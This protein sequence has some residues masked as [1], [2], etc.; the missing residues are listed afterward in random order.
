MIR[1]D[2][3]HYQAA[4]ANNVV[5]TSKRAILERII[6][7]A[8]VASST[9][10]VSDHASD[11]D[12]NVKILLTGSTLMTANGGVV[13]VGALFKNGISADI[14]AQSNVTFIWKPTV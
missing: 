7:G 5:V 12:G 14:T 4:A 3:I 1:Q 2:N 10:E 8:D 9:I 6:I 11:G 13:E